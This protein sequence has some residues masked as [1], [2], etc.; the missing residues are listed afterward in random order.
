MT[1][2]TKAL[3]DCAR[4]MEAQMF[5]CRS[6]AAWLDA[7][8]PEHAPHTIS[9]HHHYAREEDTD[10]AQVRVISGGSIGHP[11]HDRTCREK[12]SEILQK[13]SYTIDFKEG[14]DIIPTPRSFSAKHLSEHDKISSIR[15]IALIAER[16][17]EP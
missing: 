9:L 1:S 8:Y 13:L 11:D 6:L 12:V 14:F 17:I 15:R 7:T 4:A 5:D 10:I 16:D 3:Q 2:R